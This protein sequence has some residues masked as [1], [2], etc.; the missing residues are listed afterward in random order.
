MGTH[1]N[2]YFQ[3]VEDKKVVVE[4]AKAE[5]ETAERRLEAKKVEDGFEEPKNTFPTEETE[6]A[7]KEEAEDQ[8]PTEEVSETKEE[9]EDTKK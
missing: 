1:I 2:A 5:L 3:D 9:P 7:K 8:E 4:L 6:E